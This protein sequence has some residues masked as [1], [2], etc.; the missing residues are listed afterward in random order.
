MFIDATAIGF[1]LT[2]AIRRHVQ[3]RLESALGPF[4]RFVVRAT[5]RIQDVN[6]SRGGSDKRCSVLVAL[7]RRGVVAAGVTDQDLYAAVNRVAD[8]IRRAV[9]RSVTRR[10]S[11]E[12]RDSQRLSTLVTI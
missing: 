4:A 7:R 11:R 3:S 2:E 9:K 1:P 8:R 10:L 5:V 6:S 12:R